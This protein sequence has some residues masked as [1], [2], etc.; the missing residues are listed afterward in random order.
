MKFLRAIVFCMILI[1]CN[2]VTANPPDTVEDV[3][4]VNLAGDVTAVDVPN[5]VTA[6]DVENGDAVTD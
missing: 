3:D 4:V 6:V 2:P 1:G 5:D